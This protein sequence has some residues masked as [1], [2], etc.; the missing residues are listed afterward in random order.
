MSYNL[1][2]FRPGRPGR[3]IV[4]ATGED[5][6]AALTERDLLTREQALDFL[7]DVRLKG[8]LDLERDHDGTYIWAK[9]TP[10]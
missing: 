6:L 3:T 2:I 4:E 1:E 5:A 7:G 9:V 8:E 10:R